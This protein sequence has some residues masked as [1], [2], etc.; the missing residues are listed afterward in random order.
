LV[1]TLATARFRLRAAHSGKCLDL[2]SWGN[3]QQWDCWGGDNQRWRVSLAPS[4]AITVANGPADTYH[5]KCLDTD[6]S[7]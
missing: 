3:V 2:D 1:F 4:S 7:S 6:G 5:R